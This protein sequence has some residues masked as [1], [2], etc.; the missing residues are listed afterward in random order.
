MCVT[1]VKPFFLSLSSLVIQGWKCWG[2]TLPQAASLAMKPL[3]WFKELKT[4]ELF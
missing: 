4:S 3:S 1:A 2:S